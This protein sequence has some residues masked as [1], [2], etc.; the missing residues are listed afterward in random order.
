M[1]DAIDKLILRL[2]Q[3]L[4]TTFVVI[5]HDLDGT[6]QI[7]DRIA[8]LYKSKLIATGTKDEIK[9]SDNPVLKQFFSRSS[10]GPIQVV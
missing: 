1:S 2:Q 4:G 9:N 7:A 3:E 8:M 5:S 6:W 10:E